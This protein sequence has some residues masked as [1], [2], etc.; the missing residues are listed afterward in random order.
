VGANLVLAMRDATY[1]KNRASP[2]FDAFDFD[3]IYI[4]APDIQAVLSKRFVIAEG[5]LRGQP[6]DFTTDSGVRVHIEDARVIVEMLKA[7][8]LGTHV[9]KLIEVTATG[10]TRLAL[11]MT[12]QFLQYG[13]SSSQRAVEI[14]QRTGRYNLPP[15]EALRGIMF[16]NQ[17]IY[18]DSFSPIG[19]PFDS[20][21]GKTDAQL[22]RLY[23]ISVLVNSA[24][25][26]DFEGLEASELIGNLQKIGFSERLSEHVLKDLIAKRFVY[27]R[28][29]QEYTRES[30]LAP[31]R[32]AGYLVREL[33]GRM[34]F[35]ETTMFDTFIAKDGT[36]ATL[37]EL[38][39]KIYAQHNLITKLK[40]R[41]EAVQLFFDF[42]EESMEK[43]V[44][45]ARRRGLPPVWCINPLKRVRPNLALDLTKALS[46][47]QRNYGEPDLG[48][49]SSSPVGGQ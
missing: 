48:M 31:S 14:Y 47:A 36:W 46:S 19:N 43:L 49:T 15:H 5:L 42:M 20:Y 44:E 34:M 2:V 29:H 24:A 25:T 22:L 9:G 41:K 3:A 6:I 4:D 23:I 8:I 40:T 16:G 28:S 26:R 38:V 45:E 1:V 32:L 18:R 12:R 30:V 17:S 27:S 11:Q 10:D 33:I 21:L 13:Y 39:R 37:K 7:A 35:L